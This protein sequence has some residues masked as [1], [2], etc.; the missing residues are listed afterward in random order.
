MSLDWMER[1][2]SV[3]GSDHSIVSAIDAGTAS[4]PISGS[5]GE[6][7]R[8]ES[9]AYDSVAEPDVCGEEQIGAR[10]LRRKLSWKAVVEAAENA[11]PPV[12]VL[13]RL[14]CSC[15]DDDFRIVATTKYFK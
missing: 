3:F 6:R 11:G 10:Q 9:E 2:R 12:V 14:V 1:E 5:L 8:V 13:N 4:R 15:C 7:N